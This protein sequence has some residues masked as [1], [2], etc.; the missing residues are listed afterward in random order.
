MI[1]RALLKIFPERFSEEMGHEWLLDTQRGLDDAR[2]RGALSIAWW[3]IMTLCGALRGAGMA[4]FNDLRSGQGRYVIAAGSAILIRENGNTHKKGDLWSVATIS[5]C[6]AA[7]C[8]HMAA[9]LFLALWV[10]GGMDHLYATWQRGAEANLIVFFLLPYLG[11]A[12]L[13]M[14]GVY[15]AISN[16]IQSNIPFLA[17]AQKGSLVF[18]V[19][20]TGSTIFLNW[21]LDD[22]NQS[23]KD[24]VGIYEDYPRL[25]TQTGIFEN[26][27]PGSL[28]LTPGSAV[29]VRAETAFATQSERWTQ[30]A[31]KTGE[32]MPLLLLQSMGAH[33]WGSG[34]W[35]DQSLLDH[36]KQVVAATVLPDLV[37]RRLPW[38]YMG[39]GEEARNS[40]LPSIGLTREK[41]CLMEYGRQKDPTGLEVEKARDYCSKIPNASALAYDAG[42]YKMSSEEARVISEGRGTKPD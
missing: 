31:Q 15:L 42:P 4:H 8:G 11:Q 39:T 28:S 32:A 41:W 30:F 2:Q 12:A 18:L 25:K 5:A 40:I 35:D 14:L 1:L 7:L 19:F 24:I 9:D 33:L 38:R 37:D 20:L 27:A 23:T 26:D 34:C 3:W 10:D 36:N 29:C 6:G 21:T 13:L 22:L 17:L 16:R